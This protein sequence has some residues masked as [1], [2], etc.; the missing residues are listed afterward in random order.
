LIELYQTDF[1]NKWFK[2]AV[3]LAEEMIQRFGDSA[4]QGFFDTPVE[5]ESLLVRPK[6]LQDNATPSGNALATEALLKLAALTGRGDFR[7]L[8]ESALRQVSGLAV[9]F[10]TGFGRWLGAAEFAGAQVRQVAIVVGGEGQDSARELVNAARAG[11]RPNVVVAAARHPIDEDAPELLR[12]RPLVEGKSAAYVCEG[13]VCKR[14]V[15]S[16]EELKKLL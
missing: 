13:F 2:A 5:G 11:F 6:D 3:R 8:A 4:N 16:A 10:P 1:D 9:R 12:D 7:D 15:T 14:P